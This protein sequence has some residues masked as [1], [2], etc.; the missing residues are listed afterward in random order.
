ML[1]Y[2]SCVINKFHRKEQKEGITHQKG[3]LELYELKDWWQKYP[4]Q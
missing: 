3:L 1:K 4:R 2:D